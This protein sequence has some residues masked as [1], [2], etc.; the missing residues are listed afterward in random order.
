MFG[1]CDFRALV[2]DATEIARPAKGAPARLAT[3][4]GGT[5][6]LPF[7]RFV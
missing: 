4:S 5:L 1:G 6:S 2:G 7:K 3:M